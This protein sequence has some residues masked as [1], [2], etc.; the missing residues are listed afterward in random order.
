MSKIPDPASGTRV[1]CTSPRGCR[2]HWKQGRVKC[3]TGFYSE[4]KLGR[5]DDGKYF[6]NK[7]YIFFL[8]ASTITEI[9]L[10]EDPEVVAVREKIFTNRRE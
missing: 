3:L 1:P 5:V 7:N 8:I 4:I 6:E 10:S 2:E 9:I